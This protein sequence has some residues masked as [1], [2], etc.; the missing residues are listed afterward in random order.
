VKLSE[1]CRAKSQ[2]TSLSAILFLS[3]KRNLLGSI[4]GKS[5]IKIA[6]LNCFLSEVESKFLPDFRTDM[7]KTSSDW[8]DFYLSGQTV[9][10]ISICLV[11]LKR[12]LLGSIYGKSSIK[13]AQFIPIR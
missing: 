10:L 2:V 7:P 9:R 3:L 4:Y 8:L 11:V 1:N 6:Q 13:I 5:S 12:N